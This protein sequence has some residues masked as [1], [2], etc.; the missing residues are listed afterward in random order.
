MAVSRS[1][2]STASAPPAIAV[3]EAIH[4]PNSHYSTKN[5]RLCSTAV[6][7]ILSM[8]SITVWLDLRKSQCEIGT[9]KIIV[10]CSWNA[11]DGNV[12]S[13]RKALRLTLYR[14]PLLQLKHRFLLL[15]DYCMPFQFL[16][17]LLNSRQRAVFNMVPPR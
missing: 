4:C 7:L 13:R 9:I 6:S 2:K 17:L 5:S 16:D 14:R 1:G 12:E 11:Q 8:A 15:S 3:F 10:N